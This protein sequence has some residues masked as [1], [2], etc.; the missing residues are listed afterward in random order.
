[1][2][3]PAVYRRKKVQPEILWINGT[4]AVLTELN[5]GDYTLFGGMKAN[6]AINSLSLGHWRNGGV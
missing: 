3:V 1:M 4:Y 5:G 6:E 2:D